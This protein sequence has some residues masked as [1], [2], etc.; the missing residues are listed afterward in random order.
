M[1][2]SIAPEEAFNKTS[3]HNKSAYQK[4]NQTFLWD[5]AI[6]K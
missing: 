1:R 2:K 5:K 4:K 6:T 3:P